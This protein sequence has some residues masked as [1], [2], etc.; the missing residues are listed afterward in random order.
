MGNAATQEETL[1]QVA[2]REAAEAESEEVT[3]DTDMEEETEPD[4]PK[5]TPPKVTAA[6]RKAANAVLKATQDADILGP[7]GAVSALLQLID[8]QPMFTMPEEWPGDEEDEYFESKVL[9]DMAR[10]LGKGCPRITVNPLKVVF[11]WRN[12]EKW[13]AG[14]KT[15][16]GN[17][18]SFPTRVRYLLENRVACVE[19]NFHHYKTLNPLQRIF[20]L[21][22]ELRQLSPDGGILK[23]DFSGFYDEMEIFGARTFRENMELARVMELGAQVTH[24]HQLPLF[25]EE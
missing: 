21:Y 13:T 1:V 24:Q 9:E 3:L 23:P 7:E 12:K 25:D 20:T 14:G 5:Y 2:E 22:H 6:D 19:I 15:V 18:K 10:I 16:R 8:I 4:E 11:L 17:V